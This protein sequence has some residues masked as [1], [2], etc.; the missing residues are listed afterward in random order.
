LW[1]LA[2]NA[3]Q[4]AGRVDWAPIL[5]AVAYYAIFTGVIGL[6]MSVLCAHMS[7]CKGRSVPVA[8]WWGLL[9]GPVGV[10]V[11]RF[12]EAAGAL[13]NGELVRPPGFAGLIDR[14][15]VGAPLF[16]ILL[17]LVSFGGWYVYSWATTPDRTGRERLV[18]A[19]KGTDDVPLL[20]LAAPEPIGLRERA[21]AVPP[22]APLRPGRDP[23]I[24]RLRVEAPENPGFAQRVAPAPIQG[25]PRQE[26]EAPRRDAQAGRVDENV[27]R[28]AEQAGRDRQRPQKPP[29]RDLSP[30]ERVIAE[31]ER[32][33]QLRNQRM[34]RDNARRRAVGMPV[35]TSLPKV[36]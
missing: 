33:L 11:V 1:V 23:V 4:V 22:G 31:R 36:R 7:K 15:V 13:P 32:T 8:F 24:E 6:P 5:Q 20:K 27:L 19:I 18:E 9:T 25:Q 35:P 12:W 16:L 3:S 2:S 28:Q 17:A 29:P 34:A 30:D 10:I 21:V 26:P 14:F